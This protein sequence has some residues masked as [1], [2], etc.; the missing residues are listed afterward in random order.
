MNDLSHI[1]D[2]TAPAVADINDDQRR[3]ITPLS[4][5]G[6]AHDAA[7][8]ELHDLLL[9]ASHLEVQRRARAMGCERDHDLHDIALQA[10]DDALVLVLS[11]LT[12]FA[13][14]SRFTTWAFK[15][16]IN[17]AGVAVRRHA[18]RSRHVRPTDDGMREL[19]SLA[20]STEA[21]VEQRETLAR[22][23]EAI[24]QLTAHQ[25]TVLI[26]LVIDGVPIDVLA[27]RL[28][29]NRN[30]LYKTLHDARRRVRGMLDATESRS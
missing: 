25:R 23:T 7:V 16:A 28:S 26:A 18:W 15:F 21:T 8:R 3:W 27:E 13:G 30:A 11:R 19:A 2:R 29:T 17:T 6:S 10:A 12:S 1:A 22:I 5:T 9:R 20:A 4:T 14:R 24:R